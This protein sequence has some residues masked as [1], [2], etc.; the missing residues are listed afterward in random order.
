MDPEYFRRLATHSAWANARTLEALDPV[1]EADPDIGRLFAHVLETE[2]IYLSRMRGEDPWPQDFW[3]DLSLGACAELAEELPASYGAFLDGLSADDLARPVRYRNSGGTEFHTSIA[4]LLT[5]VFMHG[6][7]HRG[8][9]AAAIRFAG[10]EPAATDYIVF[11][12]E[13]E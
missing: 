4:D 13:C 6:S 1:V 7:Y 5:H 9:I 11:T 2:R 8:Q 10:G 3:P 12:R